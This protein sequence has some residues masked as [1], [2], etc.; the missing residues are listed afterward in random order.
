MG[1][2]DFVKDAGKALGIG[3]AEAAEAPPTPEALKKEID[4]LG[5][6]SEGLEVEVDGDTVKVTGRAPTEEER[7]KIILAAGNIA[8]VARV[9]DAIETPQPASPPVFHTVVKGD[10]LWKIAEK[11]LGKGARYNEIF[12]ANRPM[13]KD[14]DKIYPGQVL[15]IPKQ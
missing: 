4:D 3:G 11:T 5:L 14:P 7:E 9:E 2:W 12:E 15:R 6:K 1:L 8:G 10:S 13:L